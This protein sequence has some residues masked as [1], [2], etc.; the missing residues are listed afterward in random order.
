MILVCINDLPDGLPYNPKLFTS[1]TCL[2]STVDNNEVAADLNNNLIEIM[3]W[4]FQLKMSFN[5]D[6]SKQD[7]QVIFSK[8]NYN[9]SFFSKL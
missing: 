7:Q 2:F 4:V 5:P 9:I 1:D 3:Q 8:T 6:I